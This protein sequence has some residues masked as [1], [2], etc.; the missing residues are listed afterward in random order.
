MSTFNKYGVEIPQIL[1]PKK[2]SDYKAWSVIACDQY[3]QDRD[4]WARCEKN[5]EGKPSC[6]N[7]ILPE[8]YLNDA[9]K[10]ERIAKIHKNMNT[11]T[12]HLIVLYYYM[13]NREQEKHMLRML[14]QM[15][16]MQNLYKYH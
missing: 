10:A 13:V 5:A 11:S 14:L 8:V 16:W 2:G 3:T 7:L 1:L 4:Y 9:D 12:S 6:I 15:K